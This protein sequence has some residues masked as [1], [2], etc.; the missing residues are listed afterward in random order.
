[1]ALDL[2]RARELAMESREI[3]GRAGDRETVLDDEILLGRIAILEG[4]HESGMRDG[5]RAAREA[6]EAGYEGVGVTG[7]RNLALLATRIMDPETA[8]MAMGEGLEYADAIEQSHCRQMLATTSALLSWGAGDWDAADARARQDLSDRGCRRGMVGGLDVLGLVALGRG[9]SEQARRWLEE[10]LG[11]GRRIGEV[12][13]LLTP[14]WGLAETDL[15][16]GKVAEAVTRCEEAWAAASGSGERALFVP[17]VVTGTRAFIAAKRPDEAA[18]WVARAREFLAGWDSV[19]GA[20]LSHAD[21]LV[22]LAA[23]T[24]VASREALERAVRG[25]EE[26]G[27]SWEA[28]SARLD[29]AGCLVRVNRQAGAAELVGEVRGWALATGSVPLL[30]RADGLTQA[31][32]GRGREQEPWRPLT[33]RE[34]EVAR[35]VADGLTNGEIAAELSLSPKTVSAHVEHILAKLGVSRRTEIAAWATAV[36]HAEAAS[37]TRATASSIPAPR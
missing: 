27:R 2:T 4:N 34:F 5:L 22:G 35:L 17:F 13:L 36:R 29:L 37:A 14:L 23:G 10:S 26:R 24:L 7:Y 21:G 19:A 32:R 12:H 15:Q 30:Q 33:V 1:M 18:R 11:V 8:S 6:R 31:L 16:E 28:Q 20:A 25:W 9:R 3:A